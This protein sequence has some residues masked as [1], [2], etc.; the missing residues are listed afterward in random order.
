MKNR[1]FMTGLLLFGLLAPTVT[2]TSAQAK[3]WEDKYFCRTLK[4]RVKRTTKT[5]KIIYSDIDTAHNKHKKGP[6][7]H[8]GDVVYTT[9]VGTSGF[10]WHLSGKKCK[11]AWGYGYSVS[12][13]KGAFKILKNTKMI[14]SK[15]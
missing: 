14:S 15:L 9:Y 3:N 13:K 5:T 10:D 6:T 1:V 2:T 11:P 8:K 7:L 4:V 12:W